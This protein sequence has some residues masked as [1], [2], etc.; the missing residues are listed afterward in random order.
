MWLGEA[1][2]KALFAVREPVLLVDGVWEVCVV[3]QVVVRVCEA[4][5]AA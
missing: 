2:V 4:R 3:G 1:S 5:V